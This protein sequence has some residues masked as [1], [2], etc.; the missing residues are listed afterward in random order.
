MKIAIYPLAETDIIRQFRYYLVDRDAPDA[1]F[2]FRDAV[3]A[4]MEQLKA[5]PRMGVLQRGGING[6]RSWPVKG[7]EQI[8]IYYLERADGVHVLRVLDGRRNVRRL[9]N[10]GN[11]RRS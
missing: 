9:L 5:H 1:A 4:S 6:L 8:R 3:Q 2:R 10:P 7:F 11:T